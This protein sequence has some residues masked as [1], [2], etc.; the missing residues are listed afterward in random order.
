MGGGRGRE[1]RVRSKIIA[2]MRKPNASV[3]RDMRRT[4][5]LLCEPLSSRRMQLLSS[6]CVIQVQNQQR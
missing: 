2:E 6:L 4:P 3:Q 5:L 1:E